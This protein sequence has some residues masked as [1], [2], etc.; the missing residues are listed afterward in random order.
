MSQIRR[1][2]HLPGGSSQP[3][4]VEHST[5][6]YVLY[7]DYEALQRENERLT[8]E[9]TAEEN[10]QLAAWSARH[11]ISYAFHKLIKQR[12]SRAKQPAP[13]EKP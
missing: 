6:A 9:P 13:Q 5:G 11:G 4:I 7:S 12:A 1:F 2:G 10:L 3:V 8:N